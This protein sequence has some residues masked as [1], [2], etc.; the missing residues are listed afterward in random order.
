MRVEGAGHFAIDDGRI[1]A[2][3]RFD[4]IWVLRTNT[5][6]P[7]PTVALQY[8][9]LWMV[10]AL[11]RTTKAILET[12]PIYHK[13]DETI[14]GHVFCSFLALL[15]KAELEKRLTARGADWEWAEGLR[16]LDT[17]Q[18]V[19]AV[20]RGRHYRLRSQFTGQA[21]AAIRAAGVAVPPTIREV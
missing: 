18:D 14:R 3:A 17:L 12:R 9:R 20:F 11:I 8:K 6:Y 5:D 15:L 4:G 2:E 13:C 16:G 1:T 7:A 19:A 10:E 21:Y